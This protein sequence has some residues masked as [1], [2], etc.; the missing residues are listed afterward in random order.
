MRNISSAGIVYKSKNVCYG[1][2]EKQG[3]TGNRRRLGDW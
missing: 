3:S 2:T 1:D